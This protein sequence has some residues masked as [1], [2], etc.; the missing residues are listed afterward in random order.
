MGGSAFSR[1][2]YNDRVSIR[3]ST[4]RAK[5]IAYTSAVFEH[6]HNIRTGKAEEKV[7]ASLEP[8]GVKIREARDSEV[9]PVSVPIMIGLDTTGSMNTVPSMIQAA[10][11][12]LIGH[13]IDD[14]ASGK[15]YLGEGYPAILISAC[16]DYAAQKSRGIAHGN[17]CLQVGQFESGIEIDDN[18]SN[19]WLTGNGGGT[20]F[21]NYDLLVYFAARHTSHDHWEKRGRKGYL[22]LIGDEQAYDVN[23]ATVKDV[24]GDTLQDDIPFKEIV[25][26]AQ[27]RYHIFFVIPKMT[28]HY[29]EKWLEKFWTSHLGQNVLHLENPDK[30]CELIV[31][32]VAIH[33]E[34]VG[35]DDLIAD[36][37]ASGLDKALVPMAKARGEVSKH[38]AAG[39]PAVAGSS[40]GTE[41]L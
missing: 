8:K 19:L 12:K 10:L 16:D 3:S 14:K 36:N 37:V 38:S 17:G 34:H 9:H 23:Q 7:H 28:S 2:D 27:E 18:L 13:F 1:D 39:L 30:I 20:L 25:K 32:T 22:F 4:A 11:P 15:K 40:S 33:E 26:E 31:S 29:H 24:I 6:D 35:L 5:G 21:E 41:R